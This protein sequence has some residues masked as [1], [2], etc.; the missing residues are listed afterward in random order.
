L[1]YELNNIKDAEI[2]TLLCKQIGNL[3]TYSKISEILNLYYTGYTSTLFVE[4]KS[5]IEKYNALS[6]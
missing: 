3:T 2:I 5:L 6:Q 4:Y 1:N